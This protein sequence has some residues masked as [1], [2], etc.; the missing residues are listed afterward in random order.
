MC[1][2]LAGSKND[3]F[4]ERSGLVGYPAEPAQ[5]A[6]RVLGLTVSPFPLRQ[7]EGPMNTGVRM[8]RKV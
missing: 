3:R 6:T 7:T 5:S 1:N 2:G 8:G 4:V